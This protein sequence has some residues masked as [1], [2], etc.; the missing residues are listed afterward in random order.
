M[1]DFDGDF[2]IKLKSEFMRFCSALQVETKEEGI[3]TLGGSLLGSQQYFVD[4]VFDGLANGVHYFVILKG[5]QLGISTICLALDLFWAFKFPGMQATLAVDTEENREGFRTTL[6]LYIDGLPQGWKLPQESHNRTHLVL[7]NRSRIIYQVAGTRKNVGFGAGKAIT[8][9]HATEVGKWGEGTD[10]SSFEASLAQNNP[11]RLYIW[12]STAYG[13][14]MFY[15][16]WDTAMTAESQKAIFIGWWRNKFY[17]VERDSDIFKVY[18]DGNLTTEERAW[19]SEVKELYDF[20]VSAE[21][22]AWHRWTLNEQMKG[23]EQMMHE[24]YP[25]TAEYAFIMTGSQY[26]STQRLTDQMKIV[27]AKPY[28]VKRFV[29]GGAFED[30]ELVDCNEKTAT[31]KIWQHPVPKG[32]YVIGADPAWGSSE[33]A[34]RFAISVNRCWADG[35]EQVAEFC[36]PECNTVQFAWVLLYLS[37]AYGDPNLQANMMFNL[38]LN[39]PGMAVWNEIQILK[40]R[41]AMTKGSGSLSRILEKP[42]NFLYR[43]P[44]SLQGGYAYHTKTTAQEKERFLAHMKDQHEAGWLI[45]NSV[46]CLNEMKNVVRHDGTIGVPGRGKDDRVIAQALGVIAW[47]DFI[48]VRL[49][50]AGITKA[51]QEADANLP[52]EYAAAGRSVNNFL[53][54]LGI[55]PG[56]QRPVR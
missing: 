26:F 8:Y 22:V 19:V 43:K 54:H 42:Q 27:K 3:V 53:K 30:T 55:R 52:P 37:A 34:D 31:L 17:A 35:M 18:W 12:E 47:V 21:Q 7:K 41:A 50:Q 51:K 4:E 13:Y 29:F 33:W 45:I 2:W 36:T 39:G 49:I 28:E 24:K 14:G 20:D 25:P 48:R 15:D 11:K 56:Q 16:M 5:R 6:T 40:Q 9:C 10:L 44:D 38:E 1:S 46:D 23:D 32:Q